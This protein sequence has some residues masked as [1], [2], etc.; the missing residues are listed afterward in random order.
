MT[1]V[2]TCALPIYIPLNQV[3]TP[4]VTA[5]AKDIAENRF[6]FGLVHLG[7]GSSLSN[8]IKE[9]S[10][11]RISTVGHD[12]QS[13]I[14]ITTIDGRVLRLTSF[15]PVLVFEGKM[16]A[17]KSIKQT[18]MLV[19]ESGS[20]VQIKSVETVPFNGSVYNF[21]SETGEFRPGKVVKERHVI[22]AN[23]LAVGDLYWQGSLESEMNRTFLRN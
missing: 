5:S 17:A 1:G 7:E 4:M 8:M 6:R 12:E 2:Q 14:Q 16:I 9:V 11:V 22:F 18:D 19:D 13:L 15:H 10:N 3:N 23:K 21:S 20:P